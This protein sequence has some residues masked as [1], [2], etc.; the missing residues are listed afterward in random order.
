MLGYSLFRVTQTTRS[1]ARTVSIPTDE[2]HRS[3]RQPLP[4]AIH[5]ILEMNRRLAPDRRIR[6]ICVS[7]GLTRWTQAGAKAAFEEARRAGVFVS[8]VDLGLEPYG[9][10]T[11]ASPT[12]PDAYATYPAA[13]SWAM[14]YWAGRYIL[15]SRDDPKMTPGAF[16]EQIRRDASLGK[17]RLTVPR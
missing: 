17:T 10:V 11:V 1:L 4:I 7:I 13:G 5:R 14:A 8:A 16:L 12:A 9:P 15:A 3:R 2:A 6:A